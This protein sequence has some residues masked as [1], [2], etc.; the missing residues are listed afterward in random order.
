MHTRMR[1][2]GQRQKTPTGP[3][4]RS[5]VER[6]ATCQSPDPSR[7]KRDILSGTTA[8]LPSPYIL[9]PLATFPG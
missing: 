8:A 4:G 2:H 6:V 9:P 3:P 5:A 1:A 7:L